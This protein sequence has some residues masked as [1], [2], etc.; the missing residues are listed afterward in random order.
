MAGEGRE[1]EE[2][3]MVKGEKELEINLEEENQELERDLSERCKG[4]EI[5][6]EGS[7]RR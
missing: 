4:E 2:S 3:R 7:Q 5:G 6:R 1:R